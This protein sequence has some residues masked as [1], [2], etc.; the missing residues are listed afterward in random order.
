[1]SHAV[2]EADFDLGDVLWGAEAIGKEIGR[3]PKQTYRLLESGL[4]PAKKIADRWV[5]NKRALRLALSVA[6]EA[7]A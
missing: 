2:R 6:E 4:I 7:G 3:T 5:S 1:M